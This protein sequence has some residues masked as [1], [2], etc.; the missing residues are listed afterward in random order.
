MGEFDRPFR[1]TAA[2]EI[3]A[4]TERQLRFDFERVY[5]DIYVRK[6]V[7]LDALARAHAA[8][9]WAGDD[10]I[11]AGQSAAV[12]HGSKWIRSDAPAEVFRT[13]SRRAPKGLI[14]HGDALS[15]DEFEIVGG[16]LASTPSRT[17]FDL[18]RRRPL[19]VAVAAV[20]A[21]ANATDLKPRDITE[22]AE[23]HPGV[24]GIVQLREVVDL[25]DS[26]AESPQETRSRLVLIHGG[27]PRPT[28]QIQIRDEYGQ[29][30]ARADL[31]WE[32]WKVIV[33]Y[34]GLQHWAD[35]KQRTWDIERT[36]MLTR[37]GW[38]VIRVNSE[39]LRTRPHT[40]VRRVR[41]ALRA[42]G[43]PI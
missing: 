31:G 19:D 42:A 16:V 22:L 43:A 9:Q 23:N 13:G 27:L 36:E 24:R 29:I 14:V 25:M 4:L 15:P 10:G 28:T 33:E 26:G 11:L 37:L 40:V 35:E 6:G 3:G 41:D 1:G 34:D 38:T 32:Q 12:V 17:A 30:F 7:E 20:D 2:V 5:R 21:L 18:G 8:A 39:Q